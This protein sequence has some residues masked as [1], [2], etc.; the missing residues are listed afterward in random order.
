MNVPAP[1]FMKEKNQTGNLPSP[2]G[3]ND[4]KELE[5]EKSES[6]SESD[7]NLLEPEQDDQIIAYYNNNGSKSNLMSQNS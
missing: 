2:E 6:S 4:I 5:C 7:F 3:D 1:K